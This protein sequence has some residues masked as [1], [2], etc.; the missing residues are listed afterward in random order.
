[1]PLPLTISCFSKIQIGFTFLVAAHPGSPGQRAVKRVC[2]CVFYVRRVDSLSNTWRKERYSY[3]KHT[4]AGC[5][6]A[7]SGTVVGDI[8]MNQPRLT[9][10]REFKVGPLQ[11]TGGRPRGT[12]VRCQHSLSQLAQCVLA[13]PRHGRKP[14]RQWRQLGRNHLCVDIWCMRLRAIESDLVPLNTALATAYH[15]HTQSILVGTIIYTG[16]TVVSA[17]SKYDEPEVARA[18]SPRATFSTKGHHIWMSHERPCF[19]C[20]VIWPITSLKYDF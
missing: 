18:R 15:R 2:V 10:I 16:C 19:I 1:M 14:I 9:I 8:L 7:V 13:Y 17:T 3:H 12:H 5:K 11:L 4:A 20:F 6:W